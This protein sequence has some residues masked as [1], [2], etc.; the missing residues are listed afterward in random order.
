LPLKKKR[1]G[2]FAGRGKT[3]PPGSEKEEKAGFVVKG[4]KKIWG[5]GNVGWKTALAR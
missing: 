1:K 3:K 5:K 2:T 4:R